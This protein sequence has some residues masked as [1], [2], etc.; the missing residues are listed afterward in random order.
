MNITLEHNGKHYIAM[1]SDRIREMGIPEDVIK[2]AVEKQIKLNNKTLLRSDLNKEVGDTQTQVGI[3]ADA[4][5]LLLVGMAQLIKAI[6]TADTMADLKTKSA[7][8]LSFSNTL[9]QGLEQENVQL[10]YEAKGLTPE[11]T[12]EQV[13]LN[14]TSVAKLIQMPR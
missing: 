1:D 5:A 13:L 7:G 9:L 6:N 10:P 11:Q 12:A 3:T 4:L 14:M 2:A 8:L